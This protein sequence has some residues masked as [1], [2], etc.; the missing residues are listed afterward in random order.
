MKLGS[1]E[2]VIFTTNCIWRRFKL[3]RKCKPNDKAP[4]VSILK[5]LK[6]VDDN[7]TENLESFFTLD[8]PL[9]ELLFCVQ[10][11][12]DP[13]ILVVRYLTQKYPKVDVRVFYGSSHTRFIL[14]VKI[15]IAEF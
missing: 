15:L 11:P 1:V 12:N 9:Y 5:A 2:I 14:F 3:H 13:A 10:D 8:Y 7:L 6:G 4:G